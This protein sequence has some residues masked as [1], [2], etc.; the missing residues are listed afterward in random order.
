[1]LLEADNSARTVV[2]IE[3]EV[4][5]RHAIGVIYTA[6][7]LLDIEGYEQISTEHIKEFKKGLEHY[8][9]DGR[10]RPV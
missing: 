6:L 9:T 7:G 8:L 2:G 10:S 5:Y 3:F 1:M 4:G